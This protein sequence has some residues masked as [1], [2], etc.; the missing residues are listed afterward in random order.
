MSRGVSDETPELRSFSTDL[1]CE[2]IWKFWMVRFLK[3]LPMTRT[4]TRT[5]RAYVWLTLKEKND[6]KIKAASSGMCLNDYIRSCVE[7]TKIPQSPPE[8]NRLTAVELGKVGVNLNQ[9]IRAMNTAIAE[10]QEI[11]NI[12]ESLAVVEK[13]Y[14]AVRQLQTELLLGE[15]QSL[16][17]ANSSE[18]VRN[19]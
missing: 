4:K 8:V 10:S 1:L 9:K 16:T 13:V 7:R 2:A 12:E 3:R 11:P 17:S 5:T 15:K 6:W 14:E 18:W 19:N